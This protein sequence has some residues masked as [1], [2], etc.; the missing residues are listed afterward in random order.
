MNDIVAEN[1]RAVAKILD[2]IKG[3]NAAVYA[4][5]DKIVCSQ[6]PKT[7]EE[8]CILCSMSIN[9]YQY[10][11]PLRK[12]HIHA[13]KLFCSLCHGFKWYSLPEGAEKARRKCPCCTNGIC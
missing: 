5:S 2:A 8:H 6:Q 4:L 12:L 10:A 13:E 1:R 9:E 7:A 3:M 11:F